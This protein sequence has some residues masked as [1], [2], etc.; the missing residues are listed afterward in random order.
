MSTSYALP[1]PARRRSARQKRPAASEP[2]LLDGVLAIPS[3]LW[4]QFSASRHARQIQYSSGRTVLPETCYFFKDL[5]SSGGHALDASQPPADPAALTQHLCGY[6][7]CEDCTRQRSRYVISKLV[8]FK[9]CLSTARELGSEILTVAAPRSH[10]STLG[11][12]KLCR[13]TA[14]FL[15]IA[16][17][18][19]TKRLPPSTIGQSKKLGTNL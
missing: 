10:G 8:S 9:P 18:R 17:T 5:G 6:T 19:S 1:P 2:V 16:Q 4:G 13:A 14:V 7:V 11:S 15:P 3:P 12:L